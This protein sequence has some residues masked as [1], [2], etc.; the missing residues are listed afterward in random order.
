MKN[1]RFSVIVAV[2]FV[3]FSIQTLTPQSK[4]MQDGFFI[5]PMN[6]YYLEVLRTQNHIDWYKQLSYNA[7]QNYCGHFDYIANDWKNKTQR[8]GGFFE[9]TSDYADYIR[10]VINQWYSISKSNSLVMERE[11][12]LRPAYGQRSTYQAEDAGSWENKFP[13]YGFSS[14]DFD[15]SHDVDDNRQNENIRS[16]RCSAGIDREGFMVKGLVDNCE[17][18]NDVRIVANTDNTSGTRAFSDIK[19]PDYENRWY[20]KPR[21][22][23]DPAFAKSN[24][25]VPVVMVYVKNFK[26]IIID[27]TLITCNNFLSPDANGNK[28]YDGSYIEIYFNL[29]EN[30]LSVPA[31]KLAD[32]VDNINNSKVD[33]EIKWL[34]KADVW[35]DYV[36]VD[37]SWA[38]FLFT[39]TYE[40]EPDNTLNKWKFHRK[41]KEEVDAFKDTPGFGYFWVD[42]CWYNN[43]PCIAEVNRLVKEY[44]GG[45]TSI[46]FIADPNA[47]VGGGGLRYKGKD[48]SVHWKS[49][50]DTLFSMGAVSNQVIC[51]FFPQLFWVLYPHTLNQD[52]QANAS[53]FILKSSYDKY[54]GDDEGVNWDGYI[55]YLNKTIKLM[56]FVSSEAK[57][58]NLTFGAIVQ[59]NSDEAMISNKDG[60]WG[61]REPTNEEIS[62]NN[63]LAMCYGAKQLFQFSYNTV[64]QNPPGFFNRGL[65]TP[66]YSGKREKNY[67]GQLKWDCVVDLNKQL[68]KIGNVM[69]PAGNIKEHLIYEGTATVDNSIGNGLPF[70]FIQDIRSI[71]RN[72]SFN[73]NDENSNYDPA[74][75]RFW[76]IGFFDINP[77]SVNKNDKSK[78][79]LV[80]NKRTYPE[81]NKDGD[82]RMLKIMFKASELAGSD[83]WVIKDAVTGEVVSTF[84]KNSND[85]ISAGVFNPGEG[86]LLKLVPVN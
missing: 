77:A 84:N 72:A 80:L 36:R 6:F 45:T 16:K 46:T 67:Y 37:D 40:N 66:G 53:K 32:G 62:V 47:F 22:R 5:G 24:P 8:D 86:K 9:E 61:L 28:S 63:F 78:F 26:G 30:A 71:K 54:Y 39:D 68:M 57:A 25:G 34:G 44:S 52:N 14:S 35:L 48:W 73:F 23:I 41:I 18:I 21:M 50:Y 58:K 51:Q 49:V 20:I 1:K 3:M 43:I 15:K 56:R 17:Q 70:K 81:L 19:Q 33:Y 11:K 75:K 4:H 29:P 59:L 74:N 2:V 55:T 79:I 69:Y 10:N 82:L 83:N 7:M 42:E 60:N 13:A 64:E 31:V 27:S 76:E 65:T 85:Y 12:I 38:H